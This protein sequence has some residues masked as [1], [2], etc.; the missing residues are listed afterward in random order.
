M[1]GAKEGGAFLDEFRAAGFADAHILRT[2]RNARTKNPK[3]IAA[4]F[5]ARR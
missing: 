1:A 5:R 4:E 3:V 2:T